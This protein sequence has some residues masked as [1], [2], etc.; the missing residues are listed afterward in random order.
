MYNNQ[1]PYKDVVV[2]QQFNQIK[3]KRSLLHA[4]LILRREIKNIKQN[5]L[6]DQ[7]NSA[8]LIKGE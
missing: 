4:A 3:K 8:D 7:L 1:K 6:P 2:Q 5:K